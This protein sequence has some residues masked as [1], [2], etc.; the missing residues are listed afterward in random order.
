MRP[1]RH[2]LPGMAAL[3]LLL[4]AGPMHAQDRESGP[5]AG[6]VVMIGGSIA[7]TPTFGAGIIVGR[8]RDRLYIATANHVV[9]QGNAAATGLQIRL[10]TS[11]SRALPA[12]LLPQ[13]DPE[14]DLAAISV[15]NLAA[16]GID[17]CAF[18]LDHLSPPDAVH[19]GSEVYPVGNPNG[20]AWGTPV[21]P[22]AIADITGNLIAF[23]SAFI[24]RG[25]SG[26]G[27]FT[28]DGGLV[29]MIQADEPP[30]GL[31]L[32]I[33]KITGA[34][35][36]WHYPVQL[37]VP[38]PDGLSPLSFAVRHGDA[39]QVK[40]LLAEP[41]TDVN[42]TTGEFEYTALQD[43][44]RLGRLDMVTLLLDAGAAVNRKTRS[45]TSPLAQASEKGSA[46]VVRLLIARG[47]TVN[48][49]QPCCASP[50]HAAA[51]RGALE[52]VQVLLAAGADPNTVGY[53]RQTPLFHA[54]DARSQ[55]KLPREREQIVQALIGA[56]ANVNWRGSDGDTP[57]THAIEL[58]ETGCVRIL[59]EAGADVN[60]K[61]RNG[62]SPLFLARPSR[63]KAALV[64][65]F[66]SKVDPED[67]RRVLRESVENGWAD[68]VDLLIRRGV[69]VNQGLD[70]E[71]ALHFAVEHGNTEVVRRLLS[72]GAKPG[73]NLQF[74]FNTGHKLEPAVRV[75]IVKLLV[76]NG[77]KVNVSANRFLAHVEPLYLALIEIS[78][79]DIDSAKILIAHGANVNLTNGYGA[80]LLTI[81]R[82][83]K[84]SQAV[85]LLLKAHARQPAGKK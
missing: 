14:L 65:Q 1:V 74:V 19:R 52:V 20:I 16:S 55:F 73:D 51:G 2:F 24:A 41:C 15:E 54:V 75:E 62:W 77:A 42:A 44:A 78:P 58:G 35:E 66:S 68:V 11:P 22:D 48:E 30:F 39:D 40:R 53:D 32:G 36:R 80:S 71:P 27:L 43:A 25:H 84:L 83:Q 85:D 8:E 61:G 79:P 34:F 28:G 9:R 31:A 12:N 81:A 29:G 45:G 59:L 13:A 26:G 17:P 18:S 5:G 37:R 64:L 76:E 23:Q 49:N 33:S 57:L 21:K 67:G 47:A 6:L 50:L 60:V 10:K 38:P 3:A 69:D 4:H 63:D 7:G 46:D 70:A 72:A 82:D 56:G